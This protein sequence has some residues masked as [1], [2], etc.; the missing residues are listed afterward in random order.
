MPGN[1]IDEDVINKV[2]A[3]YGEKIANRIEYVFDHQRQLY[4]EYF[5]NKEMENHQIL[6]NDKNIIEN[7]NIEIED[8]YEYEI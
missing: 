6:E 5:N 8:N 3:T 4:G 2:R 7:K 1:L